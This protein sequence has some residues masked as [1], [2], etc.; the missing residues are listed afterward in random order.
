MGKKILLVNPENPKNTYWSLDECV[1]I[2]GRESSSVPLGLITVGAMLPPNYDVTL[3]D[4]NV[5]E[6]RDEDIAGVDAVFITSMDVQRESHKEVIR[7]VKALGKIVVSGGPYATKYFYEEELI[8]TD[9]FVLGE[10]ETTLPVFLDD[11]NRGEAKRVYHHAMIRKGKVEK[12]IDGASLDR[13]REFFGEDSSGIQQVLARP[14]LDNSPVPRFDLLKE[15]A[16]LSQAMQFTRGC[17]YHCDF[18]N[19]GELYGHKMRVK[20]PEAVIKEMKT[21]YDSGHRW[22]TF[23]VDD[24]MTADRRKIKEVL[25]E[26]T[27]F[28]EN[29]GYP[30][31]FYTE[32]D[33]GIA[34][35]EE[36]LNLLYRAGF[37]R[38][39]IGIE[40]IEEP[41]LVAMNKRQ[42]LGV[43]IGEEVRRIH[44]HGI[45]VSAGFIM[46]YDQD[47]PD[48]GDRLFNFCQENGIVL[49]MAGILI[50]MEGSLLYER[51][52]EEGRLL[53][54]TSGNNT[55]EF[56]LN[57]IPKRAIDLARRE[58]IEK[59]TPQYDLLVEGVIR[60]IAGTSR[61][62]LA[63]LYD[64]SGENYY[65]RVGN[66][67]D[68][69]GRTPLFRRG[70]S[71]D[72]W[73]S[74]G[75]SVA[76]QAFG[77]SYS[78]EYRMFWGHVLTRHP[79]LTKLGFEKAITGHHFIQITPEPI[80][81]AR[82]SR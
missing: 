75:R 59:G 63:G 62:L 57:F 50:A 60:E 2:A 46:G 73:A 22:F 18:C 38:V 66:L 19:E 23:V 55:H 69:L 45:E 36:L 78:K 5:E 58:G 68:G 3:V 82:Y 37:N 4:M 71:R 33:L 10:A 41:V 27:K 72:E 34:K 47:P 14:S 42:N 77:Q 17:P 76:K 39:F 26:V 81:V 11:F 53:S 13:I 43:D 40:S 28:Q 20:S 1:E 35:D 21:L 61:N 6:L 8:G 79:K 15:G 44:Q 9:H 7:R 54:R 74:A 30:F 64:K 32:V 25:R 67:M 52:K 31:N 80:K 48:V 24:N 12:D 70:V 51:L 16:Y 56:D 65:R 29:K 49:A